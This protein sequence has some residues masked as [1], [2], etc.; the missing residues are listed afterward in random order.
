MTATAP[1]TADRTSAV[2]TGPA[3]PGAVARADATVAP[4]GALTAVRPLRFADARITGGFWAQRQ[5]VN[6]EVTIPAGWQHLHTSGNFEDLTLA[7]GDTEGRSREKFRGPLFMDSDVY[8][9]LEAVSWEAGREPSAEL[10]RWT[11]ETVA[12]VA[13]AQLDDGYVNSWVQAALGIG[14]RWA[15]LDHGHELYCAGHLAQA[16]VAR[17]R[18]T[19]RTDL[20][21]IA[22]RFAELLGQTFGRDRLDGVDGHPE[23]E[24]ALVELARTTGRPDILATARYFVDAHGRGLV[25]PTGEHSAYYSDLYPV[26]EADT[27]YGHAV[28]AVYLQTG[29]A[30]LAAETGD[31]RL[32]R[33]SQLAWDSMVGQKSYLT[34]GIGSRWEG[35]AFGAPYELSPDRAYSETCAAQGVVQW[36]WRLLLATG[37]ARYADHIERTLFNA[38]APGIN[39]AGDRF[40]YVNTLQL[41]A[42][43]IGEDHRDPVDGR[44]AWF[45]CACCPPSIMRTTSALHGYLA[46]A[47]DA[48]LQVH[49]YAAGTLAAD[50]PAGRF[51][52]TVDTAYPV[53]GRVTV[54]VVDAPAGEV[55][56]SLRVPGWCSDAQLSV[57]GVPAGVAVEPGSYARL[58]RAFAPGS[59]VV[60][61]LPMPVR[62]VAA[63]D[64]IDAI[65]GQLALTRGPLVYCFEQ[66]DAPVGVAVDDLRLAVTLQPGTDAPD[67]GPSAGPGGGIVP[68]AVTAHEPDLLGGIV[69]VS[70]PAG[71]RVSLGTRV[72][73]GIPGSTDRITALAVPYAVWANR[74]VGPMRIWTPEV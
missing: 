40:F 71:T 61:E 28:R 52:V 10:E 42:G 74:E 33:R 25:D 46:T 44:Q 62:A 6:R 12:A 34:G 37:E 26:R 21:D 66:V 30:D 19:G 27:V 36:S 31:D 22:V 5:R 63:D 24:T 14:A 35:E 59:T 55:T 41:R 15:H 49:Q 38:F 70:V 23:I 4:G 17:A 9:W 64:R 47:D 45:G 60:L 43:T 13:A 16:A 54:R 8:K 11:A 69:T 72:S 29:V 39:L 2:G 3:D 7:A 65:R 56:L 73:T 50:L 1:A 68:D 53:D 32:L 67:P 58:T 57:D 20:L 18:A 48:G 51:Q